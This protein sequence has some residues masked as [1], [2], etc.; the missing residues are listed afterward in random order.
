MNTEANT[1]EQGGGEALPVTQPRNDAEAA[2]AEQ[3]AVQGDAAA[4]DAEAKKAEEEANKRRNRTSQ[5]IDRLKGDADSARRENAEL[6]KRLDALE[7]R[8]PKQ[9]AKPPTFEGANFDP[10]ELARQ[11][12]QYEIGLARQQWEK[13]QQAEAART[14]EQQRVAAYQ[15]R[16]ASFAAD[17]PDYLE[18]VGSMD[19]DLLHQDLQRAIMAHEK[20]PQIAYQLGLND[21]DL[22]N[23]ASVRPEL[24]GHAL[25]RYASRLEAAPPTDPPAA[26]PVLAPTQPQKLI[27]Q[28]PAPAPRLGGRAPADVPPEKMTDEQWWAK[29]KESQRKR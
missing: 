29:R 26:A 13:D 12:S 7:T 25:D 9:E 21:D 1:Q 5:Y 8:L 27:S 11:T 6:R 15:A 22:F 14:S 20:G 3:A 18:V 4:K 16:V 19:T 24:I 17:K 2:I 23:L 10:V 28:A